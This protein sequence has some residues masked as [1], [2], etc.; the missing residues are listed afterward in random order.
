MVGRS[1]SYPWKPGYSVLHAE[2]LAGGLFRGSLT[3]GAANPLTRTRDDERERAVRAAYELAATIATMERL[4]TEINKDTT[5]ILP[6]RVTSL[7]SKAEQHGLLA[8]QQATLDSRLSLHNAKL[9]AAEGAIAIAASEQKAFDEQ[10]E[11]IRDQ[12]TKRRAIVKKVEYM[13][14]NNFARGDRLFDEQVRVAELEERLT[15]T[16][17][18]KTRAEVAG[19][20]AAQQLENLNLTWKAEHDMELLAL[21]QKKADFEILIESANNVYRRAT[22]QDAIASRIAEPLT[23]QYEIVRADGGKSSVIKADRSTPLLPGDV[24]VVSLGRPEANLSG[25]VKNQKAELEM[26]R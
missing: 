22:G 2:A 6:D 15:T 19:R 16:I 26:A 14:T 8:A 17:L 12:L 5:Y 9:A 25:M 24:V 13:T 20:A 7:V 23:A 21:E 3:D 10:V 11:R 18:A 4:R 1:G